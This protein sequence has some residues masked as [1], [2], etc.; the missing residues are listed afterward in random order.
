ML[1]SAKPTRATEGDKVTEPCG[2]RPSS[3]NGGSTRKPRTWLLVLAL[4]LVGATALSTPAIAAPVATPNAIVTSTGFH[5]HTCESLGN[6]GRTEGVLCIEVGVFNLTDGTTRVGGGAEAICQTVRAK[7]EVQCS[8]ADVWYGTV[9]TDGGK[10]QLGICGHSNGP[11]STP[12]EFF[13][14]PGDLSIPNGIC[15]EVQ[16]RIWA[17][18]DNGPTTGINLPG[19]NDFVKMPNLTSTLDTPWFLAGNGC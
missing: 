17:H 13:T 14:S 15:V 7:V 9:W 3:I 10:A 16:G 18:L 2:V 19:T 4:A 1:P 11:C 6:D 8:N 5:G 12:R